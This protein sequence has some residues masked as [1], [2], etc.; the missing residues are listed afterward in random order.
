MDS[1]TFHIKCTSCGSSNNKHYCIANDIEYFTSNNTYH[2]YLCSA[3]EVLFIY[4][5]PSDSLQKIYPSNYYSFNNE[6]RSFSFSVKNLLDRLFF[7]KQLKQLPQKQLKVLD[8]GGGTGTLCD[9]IKKAD[10][11]IA[12]TQI[13][14]IDANS[15]TIA[16]AKGH[17]YFC[18]KIEDFNTKEKYD[19][20]LM[21][22]L[23]EHVA[24]P[25]LI[26]KKATQLLSEEGIIIIQTPNYKSLDARVFKDQSWG[27]Y[28]CPRH[29]II[30]TKKS[31]LKLAATENLKPVYFS[32][33]QGAA[34]WT[35]SILNKLQRWK[36]ITA[37]AQKP[38]VYHP[39]FGVISIIF[40]AF[41]FIRKIFVPTSQM[42]VVL[43]QNQKNNS[44]S[45]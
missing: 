44:S 2:Y 6:T 14:D 17:Q 29:W 16:T 33:T 9:S 26:L 12:G 3:C 34:F 23:I 25:A 7:K 36:W 20:I 15:A 22:N 24:A 18:G 21:L 5:Q 8:I 19:V 27:G 10:N 42:L 28:H 13:V 41:D 11:R 30:F 35:V 32:F 43:K 4:P 38:L 31:F 45:F 37:D 39:L 1:E 40:A